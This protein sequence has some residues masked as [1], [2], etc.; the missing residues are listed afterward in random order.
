MDSETRKY[1]NARRSYEVIATLLQVT[2]TPQ[3]RIC[4]SPFGQGDMQPSAALRLL[5][6]A[7]LAL[8][9]RALHL[10]TYRLAE[11]VQMT[12]GEH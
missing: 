12:L 9:K 1:A 3:W 2:A 6:L 4:E 5:E 10:T 7:V 8:R 11:P